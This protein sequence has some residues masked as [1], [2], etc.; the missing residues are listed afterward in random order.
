[1]QD[2]KGVK[3]K[4]LF[5][6]SQSQRRYIPYVLLKGLAMAKSITLYLSMQNMSLNGDTIFFLGLLLRVCSLKIFLK[7][8]RKVEN[9][10]RYIK[11]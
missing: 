9:G 3:K 1:M 5:I 8:R 10:N 6:S 11:L 7:D 2:V 4:W